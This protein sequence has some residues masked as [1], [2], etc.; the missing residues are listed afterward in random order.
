MKTVV[1]ASDDGPNPLQKVFVIS[2]PVFSGQFGV[3]SEDVVVDVVHSGRLI[4][5][6]YG[7]GSEALVQDCPQV[8]QVLIERRVV[9]LL[10]HR[11]HF[12]LIDGR[13]HVVDVF[14]QYGVLFLV[15]C[16]QFAQRT[17]LLLANP[18]VL[19]KL[20]GEDWQVQS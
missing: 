5:S 7:D 6:G 15:L 12:Q 4:G 16:V 17:Q 8:L 1:E 13:L 19:E 10:L 20:F 18:V 2:G 11:L 9:V 14:G 3:Q